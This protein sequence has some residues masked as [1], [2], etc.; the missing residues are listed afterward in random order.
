MARQR[1]SSRTTV[2]GPR[3]SPAGRTLRVVTRLVTVRAVTSALVA[4]ILVTSVLVASIPVVSGAA[5]GSG[6]AP[7]SPTVAPTAAM[8]VSPHATAQ[9]EY[10][11]AS[12]SITAVGPANNDTDVERPTTGVTI[13]PNET[14]VVRGETNL[15]PDDNAVVAELRTENGTVVAANATD[16]WGTDGAWSTILNTSGVAP[17]TYALEVEAADNTDRVDVEVVQSTPAPSTTTSENGSIE[18]DENGS[19]VTATVVESNASTTETGSAEGG[20]TGSTDIGDESDTNGTAATETD[21][22]GDET[23]DSEESDASTPGF[24]FVSALVSAVA[25]A[26]VASM[27]DE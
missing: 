20:E 25:V 23:T 9:I 2:G 8:G 4:S 26:V 12:V 14:T 17:G 27:R 19:T 3:H 13:R 5:A 16:E 18:D 22:E 24:G 11:P 10:V 21:V 1:E 7:G 15:R 6:A